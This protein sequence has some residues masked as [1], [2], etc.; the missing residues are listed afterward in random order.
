MEG[1]YSSLLHLYHV[2][3]AFSVSSRRLSAYQAPPALL[4]PT[5]TIISQLS[6]RSPLSFVE[7]FFSPLCSILCC[8]PCA[9]QPS[10]SATVFCRCSD[11]VNKISRTISAYVTE[12]FLSRKSVTGL[13]P[14]LSHNSNSSSTVIG[15]IFFSF[16]VYALRFTFNHCATVSWEYP[17][18]FFPC[19][20]SLIYR[21]S[22][23]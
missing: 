5:H 2:F 23:P 3:E 6:H 4:S 8:S 14:N 1:I 19:V 15:V 20:F 17:L 12:A 22:E 18:F 9:V 7:V 11:I 13:I 10:I 21:I 16:F